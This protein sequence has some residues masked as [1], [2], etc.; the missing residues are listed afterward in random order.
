MMITIAKSLIIQSIDK[1]GLCW[2][3][4]DGSRYGI[5]SILFHSFFDS[6]ESSANGRD[7]LKRFCE[8]LASTYTPLT[9]HDYIVSITSLASRKNAVF[10]TF[11]D[12]KK[13]ILDCVDIFLDYGIPVTIFAACGWLQDPDEEDLDAVLASVVACFEH[14]KGPVQTIKLQN[15]D[16]LSLGGAERDSEID[17]LLN[18]HCVNPDVVRE[19]W[20]RSVMQ[21][22][23][24]TGGYSVCSWAELKSLACDNVSIASHSMSHCRMAG[25]SSLRLSFEM[26]GSR[27]LLQNH[28]GTC[29]TFAYPYGT[30]DVVSD[31]TTNVLRSAGYTAAFLVAAG[32]GRSGSPYMLPRI[33]IPDG[34]VDFSLLKS[35]VRGGQI[36]LIML[37]NQ[38]TG[39]NQ[40]TTE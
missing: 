18:L 21:N 39:R 24:S 20:S 14:Y 13:S 25:K 26:E 37:K 12:A 5:R 6:N 34:T 23:S 27:R 1:Y 22:L 35:L 16:V 8:W 28:F 30:W 11:D 38:F 31:S 2:A 7:R 33:D 10:V 3:G 17:T 19:L 40:T 29:D 9:A 15:G 32:F 36:P 4:E